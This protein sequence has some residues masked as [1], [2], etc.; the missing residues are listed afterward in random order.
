M[1]AAFV[2]LGTAAWSQE[3]HRFQVERYDSGVLTFS[4]MSESEIEESFGKDFHSNPIY[5]LCL[6][7]GPIL[8]VLLLTG[9]GNARPRTAG[10]ALRGGGTLVLVFFSVIFFVAS[11]EPGPSIF[12]RRGLGAFHSGK[13]SEAIEW[14]SR[15]EEIGGSNSALRYNTALCHFVLGREGHALFHLRESIRIDPRNPA[16]RRVLSELEHKLSLKGQVAPGR[17]I[18]PNPPFVFILIFGNLSIV[19][20]AVLLRFKR[21]GLFILSTLLFIALIG[22]IAVFLFALAERGRPV[23]VVADARGSV[24]RIPVDEAQEWMS[25][26]VG[27][28]L[29]VTGSA[30]GY[31]LVKSGLGLEGWIK[32]D[33]VLV[34]GK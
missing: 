27:T 10:G 28:S 29:L 25:L 22:A 26:D 20:L 2:A 32:D 19:S 6:L 17:N 8:S 33:S 3:G 11:S 21:A 16:T 31:Y 23:A 5:Y 1:I 34:H 7:P 13:Y 15:A 4:L 24:K 9:P 12:I 30:Q 14:F 18:H